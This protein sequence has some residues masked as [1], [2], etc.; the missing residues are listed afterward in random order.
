MAYDKVLEPGMDDDQAQR[1][2]KGWIISV[3]DAT[4]K[5]E[6]RHFCEGAGPEVGVQFDRDPLGEEYAPI[7]YGDDYPAAGSM[8]RAG[9]TPSTQEPRR[10]TA[11]ST[12]ASAPQ[13]YTS[14]KNGG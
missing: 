7:T 3:A 11:G 2:R 5:G 1:D 13:N 8:G 12:V 14:A 6:N 4:G 10:T 9:S